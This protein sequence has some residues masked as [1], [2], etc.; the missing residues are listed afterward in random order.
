MLVDSNSFLHTLFPPAKAISRAIDGIQY[1]GATIAFLGPTHRFLCSYGLLHGNSDIL[2]FLSTELY[3]FEVPVIS[4]SPL[5][6]A[7]K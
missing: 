4:Y 7:Q 1:S 2:M 6:Y 5:Y 3:V